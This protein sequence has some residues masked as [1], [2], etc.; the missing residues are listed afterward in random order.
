MEWQTSCI[1]VWEVRITLFTKVTSNGAKRHCSIR[2]NGYCASVC[3][4]ISL[5]VIGVNLGFSGQFRSLSVPQG[6]SRFLG[7]QQTQ[8]QRM[9]KGR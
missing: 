4:F 6:E 7:H 2:N 3:V 9:F 1:E 5:Y 8:N